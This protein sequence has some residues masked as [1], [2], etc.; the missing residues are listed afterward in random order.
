M[1]SWKK[2]NDIWSYFECEEIT[3]QAHK[4]THK[5][6]LL[7][8]QLYVSWFKT[9]CQNN[10]NEPT[11][12]KD[13]SIKYVVTLTIIHALK[14]PLSLNTLTH[15]EEQCIVPGNESNCQ[16]TQ[17]Y[18]TPNEEDEVGGWRFEWG[19][20]VVSVVCLC[21]FLL[22]R[23]GERTH[24]SA[25]RQYRACC[26]LR[27]QTYRA[28]VTWEREG[29]GKVG[30]EGGREGGREGKRKGV[31]EGRGARDMIQEKR[32]EGSSECTVAQIL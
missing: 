2:M 19:S 18:R 15:H 22:M 9:S 26:Y 16:H 7:W 24:M 17:Q 3:Q 27:L 11:S 10:G 25:W 31:W 8:S 5:K 6:R 14:T 13:A 21:F 1:I 12:V 23:W 32:G 28:S 30:E 29:G 4:S 20:A